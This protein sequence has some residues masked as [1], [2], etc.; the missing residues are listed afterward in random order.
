MNDG[1]LRLSFEWNSRGLPRRQRLLRSFK[2]Q[3]HLQNDGSVYVSPKRLTAQGPLGSSKAQP[4]ATSNVKT[5]A[6]LLLI[7]PVPRL[8]AG[9]VILKDYKSNRL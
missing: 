1:G 5:K 2:T 3:G 7:Y 9:L 8:C 6:R 4:L